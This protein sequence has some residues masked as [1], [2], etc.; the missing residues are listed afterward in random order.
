M[1]DCDQADIQLYAHASPCASLTSV[2]RLSP[3]SPPLT[4]L[5]AQHYT[6]LCSHD[7][8]GAPRRGGY[9]WLRGGWVQSAPL[10]CVCLHDRLFR[11]KLIQCVL[12]A[13]VH[14]AEGR[15]YGSWRDGDDQ[16][17]QLHRTQVS[18]TQVRA[19]ILCHHLTWCTH[20]TGVHTMHAHT[21]AHPLSGP[22]TLPSPR[23]QC[24]TRVH[25]SIA[26]TVH[27][28]CTG[29]AC[30]LLCCPYCTTVF[31]SSPVYVTSHT[32]MHPGPRRYGVRSAMPGFIGRRLCPQLVFVKPN[33]E[34]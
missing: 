19:L 34:R 17:G 12:R 27:T 23:R 24:C 6:Q 5:C 30:P 21:H 20:Y 18:H 22:H 3:C 15:A 4:Q 2:P 11:C 31:H 28:L 8:F 16:H 32:C 1:C 33:F 26:E 10:S 7:C 13:L 25:A 29:K 14:R 9:R